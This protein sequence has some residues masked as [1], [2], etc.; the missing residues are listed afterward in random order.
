L[1]PHIPT[2]T[3]EPNAVIEKIHIRQPVTLEPRDFAK[4]LARQNDRLFTSS[5]YAR[6][7]NAH[8]VVADSSTATS[9]SLSL[10]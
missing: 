3:S 1:D 2:F 5:G 8:D 9:P 6:T 4:S 7:G 10:L